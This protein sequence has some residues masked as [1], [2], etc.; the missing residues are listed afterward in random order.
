MIMMVFNIRFGF[1][2]EDDKKKIIS[3]QAVRAVILKSD[4][5]FMIHN[6]KG[7]YKF[8]GG[9]IDANEKPIEAL[10]R[11]VQE[12]T[13]R[14]ITKIVQ[15]LGEV[16]ERSMDKYDANAI[17]E[18]ISHYYLCEIA[19]KQ[20]LQ[21]LDEY[22]WELNFH[23]VWVALDRAI[24]QNECLLQNNTTENNHWVCRETAVLKALKKLGDNGR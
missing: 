13:G 11:E 14:F 7:D 18:H 5:V 16:N 8:P 9:G 20:G 1:Q 22:E 23:P 24:E 6:N 2:E 12:E 17:F 19:D 21:Q 3:R 15:K 4:S 10:K